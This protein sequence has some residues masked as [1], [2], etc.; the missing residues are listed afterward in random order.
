MDADGTLK[1][2]ASALTSDDAVIRQR[3][4]TNIPVTRNRITTYIG[5]FFEEGD[6]EIIQTAFGI[7]VNPEWDG[8]TEYSF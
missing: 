7:S 6:G 2:T 5:K 1:V 4:F 8:E 3:T